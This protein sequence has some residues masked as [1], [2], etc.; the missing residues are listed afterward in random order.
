ML[1]P[2]EAV[3]ILLI[4]FEWDDF[5]IFAAI[6]LSGHEVAFSL[7]P[8]C[9]VSFLLTVFFPRLECLPIAA[10]G[11]AVARDAAVNEA[12]G[13]AD[14]SEDNVRLG[15]EFGFIQRSQLCKVES[16]FV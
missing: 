3:K 10:L 14:Q 8:S 2:T 9:L 7:G 16:I 13:P 4:Q 5:V 15:V 1:Q 12:D 6:G 11:S